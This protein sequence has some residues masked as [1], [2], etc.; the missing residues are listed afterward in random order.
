MIVHDSTHDKHNFYFCKKYVCDIRRYVASTKKYVITA[1]MV[2]H[3]RIRARV[4]AYVR[5]HVCVRVCVCACRYVSVCVT[6]TIIKLENGNFGPF[7]PIRLH[8]P[9]TDW[10][11]TLPHS[12]YR[13]NM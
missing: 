1:K 2:S 6:K 3:I 4:R 5:V 7:L 13:L 8:K 10:L 9:V 12:V 11:E